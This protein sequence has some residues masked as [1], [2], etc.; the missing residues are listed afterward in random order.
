MHEQFSL[1][2]FVTAPWGDGLEAIPEVLEDYPAFGE[3]SP[4]QMR[5]VRAPVRIRLDTAG[6]LHALAD[7]PARAGVDVFVYHFDATGQLRGRTRILQLAATEARTTRIADYAV[8]A[9][10]SVYLLERIQPGG[11]SPEQNRL[12]KLNCAGET[13]WVR[14]GLSSN[15]QFDP[16]TLT[17]RITAL[18]IDGR[19]RLYLAALNPSGTIS[20]IDVA[21]GGTARVHAAAIVGGDVFMNE[22]GIAYYIAYFP[23][24]RRR[25]I[26]VFDPAS[27]HLR[28]TVFGSDAYGWLTYPLGV[29]TS[30]NVYAWKD[31]SVARVSPDGRIEVLATINGVTLGSDGVVISS[32]LVMR[33]DHSLTVEVERRDPGSW[34]GTGANRSALH[35]P[36]DLGA[37]PGGDWR[38]IHVDKNGRY[39]VF[40]GE[41]PGN[42]GRV[43]VYS[44]DGR[45]E[46]ITP[47]HS[48]LLTLESRIENHRLWT[49]DGRGRIYLPMTDGRGFKVL[50]LLPRSRAIPRSD[51]GNAVDFRSSTAP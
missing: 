9:D 35:L 43:L 17:G 42:A 11:T 38:L 28:P 50:R 7:A 45:F 33:D 30:S 13:Q 10:G 47:T 40:G 15:E 34:S 36:E 27:G 39:F 4:A 31:A 8:A 24:S 51:I 20:E 23:E 2:V 14:T 26:A 22:R 6:G 21:S 19:S 3:M 25:G 44:H 41:A 16:H 29:D 5:R 48:A 18:L 49:V 32:R 37:R 46:K 12:R 1:E